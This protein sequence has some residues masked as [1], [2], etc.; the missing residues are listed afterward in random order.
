[1][2]PK[3][4]IHDFEQILEL[5]LFYLNLNTTPNV[6]VRFQHFKG[7]RNDQKFKVWY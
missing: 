7:G 2:N 5:Q 4:Q 3:S 6:P 1:M